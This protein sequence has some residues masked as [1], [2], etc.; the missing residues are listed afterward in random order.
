MMAIT[1]LATRNGCTPISTKR[2]IERRRLARASRSRDQEDAIGALDDLLEALVIVLGKAQ[3]FD[4]HLNTSTI[5]DAHD[6]RLT[7]V[8]GQ[9]TYTQVEMLACDGHL[10]TPV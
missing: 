1:E 8:G 4:G 10:D 3:V 5:Q 6:A 9:Q 2:V 7:V